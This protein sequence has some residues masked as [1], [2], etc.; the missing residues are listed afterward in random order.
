VTA[1]LEA[2][3][4]TT[5]FAESGSLSNGAG[6]YA[7]AGTNIGADARRALLAF[8]VASVIPPGSLV[9]AAALSL[10]VSR[11]RAL[12]TA[13]AVHGILS[14]WGEGDS[15]APGEEGAGTTA[16]AG[17]ATWTFALYDVVPWTTS[18]GDFAPTPS[19]TTIVGGEGTTAT[20]ID[21]GLV[22][23]VQAWV[24]GTT[25]NYGW[26]LI[27]QEETEQTA[28]RFD[29]RTHPD[30]AYRPRLTVQFVPS[31]STTT[32][33]TTT[34]TTTSTVPPLV[35]EP[36]VDPLPL[37]AVAQPE[38]GT[39]GGSASY[40]LAVREV[41]QRLHR[42]LPLTRVW[43]FGD[44][45]SGATY[46]GPTIETTRDMPISVTWVNDLRD[47]TGA[48][49]TVHPLPVDTCLHGADDASPRTV[50]HLHG[51]HV[52]AEFDGYPEAT[53]LPGE[54][55]TYVYPNGQQAS[56][57]WYHD[58]ALGI[59]RLNVYLGL[60]GF[61]LVR[62][63]AEQGLGLPNGAFE[64][65]LVV[66]DRSFAP[67][68]SLVYP[69]VWQDHVFGDTI[70]V[71]G[72][73][74]PYLEV[75]PGKYRFRLLSG[76]TSR[77]YRLALSNGAAFHVISTDGGLLPAPVGVTEITLA[78]GERADV[79]IDFASYAPGTTIRLLND[80]PAPFPGQPGVGVVPDVM[81]FR[82]V[83]G[84]AHT[85]PM[86]TS[87]A[88]VVP[89]DEIDATVHRD[90]ELRKTSDPCTGQ[91][92]LINGLGW[93]DITERPELGETE[94]WRFVNRSGVMHP[95]HMHLVFFQV[96]DRQAFEVIGDTV[97]P[98]GP[99]V[100]PPPEEAGWKDTVRVGP[101]EMVRVIARFDDYKGR[102]PY[103]C[104]IL[105]HEDHEMMRQ[106]ET[107]SCGDGE[108]DPGEACDDG[109]R[110]PGDGCSEACAVEPT[111]TT[112]TTSTS[113]IT[114]TS[115]T[116]T[117]TTTVPE[118]ERPLKG[119]RLVLVERPAKPKR[120][121]LLVVSRDGEG[122]TPRTAAEF[123]T[124]FA[125]GASL[126]VSAIGGDAFDGIY[127][128]PA[129]GWTL[130]KPS[131]P[132]KGVRYRGHSGPIRKV[133]LRGGHRLRIVGKGVDLAVGL[134][135]EPDAVRIELRAG[136]VRYCLEFGGEHRRFRPG[137]RLLRTDAR[138]PTAC[139]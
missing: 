132:E 41:T 59:T 33:P 122:L 30:A 37:P 45:A 87:L 112:T 139:D 52:P 20:W 23:D 66:Q 5:I 123:E 42:D 69:A 10:H 65:P 114:S 16:A 49:R 91:V 138:A 8:D 130:L 106:F 39:P 63:P 137:K 28:K 124:L 95:M 25:P 98:V 74:W 109:N 110:D 64:I 48:L 51:G 73:V 26:I 88:P 12:E 101:T 84:P 81:E 18:G 111:S 13:V 105:E 58:H 118:D 54:E 89:L 35:L 113:T 136:V 55:S 72:T 128:L 75:T 3:R 4:D 93:D 40:R 11:T 68:G 97:T 78:S 86:P 90:L 116:S 47:G 85:A 46:P 103:H 29:G 100:A 119:A 57:L 134:T 2:E 126:H 43:G 7:F 14:D 71:N 6:H 133:I 60:A 31:G 24:D 1:Y 96:L 27:G 135:T 77:T 22:T 36:F 102:F 115:S 94:V 108:L 107:V 53:L 127:D 70:L 79:V 80:A 129:A 62:D 34:S 121:R 67:D 32:I 92:W 56:T 104:H 9:T 131:K 120:R 15:D 38:N 61:Y 82:V 99:R 83:D 125:S 17:D 44:A 76:S 19:A 117:T 50:V 21:A